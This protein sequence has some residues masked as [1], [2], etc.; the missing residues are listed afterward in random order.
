MDI[1]LLLFAYMA[2]AAAFFAPCC[3]AMLP[4][5]IAY[6]VRP[7]LVGN[8]ASPAIGGIP[9]ALL[10]AGAVPSALAVLA[11]MV[12][13]LASLDLAPRAIYPYIPTL[14]LSVTLL[15]LGAGAVTLGVLAAGRAQET[16]RGVQ[17]AGL[18]TLGFFVAFLAIGLPIGL[19]AQGLR[20]YLGYLS[21]LVGLTLFA[22]GALLLLGRDLK[23]KMPSWRADVSSASGFFKFG[24]G[25]AIAGLSCTFPVF[26]GVMATAAVS[27]GPIDALLTFAA[28]ATGKASVLVALTVV[29]VAG[30]ADLAQRVRVHSRAIMR[31]SAWMLTLAGAYMTYY[32]TRILILTT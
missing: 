25:Y 11:L 22:I 29:T 12:R 26:L 2:G 17:F 15:L 30:G 28:Y 18:A 5:Y 14:D 19:L 23:V 20:P 6:A 3:I 13:G 4:A 9:K 16:R 27:G 32:Y 7:S 31:A 24:L 8:D 10:L 21:A 1:P